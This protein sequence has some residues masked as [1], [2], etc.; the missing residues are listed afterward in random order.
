MVRLPTMKKQKQFELWANNKLKEI[1]VIRPDVIR[2]VVR[3]FEE[4]LA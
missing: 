4:A 3:D 2:D 1:T